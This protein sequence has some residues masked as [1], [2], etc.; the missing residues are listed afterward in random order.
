MDFK[1]LST[2]S[3]LADRLKY[4]FFCFKWIGA[5]VVTLNFFAKYGRLVLSLVIPTKGLE[6]LNTF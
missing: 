6:E 4:I 3:K 2:L 5:I 1:N